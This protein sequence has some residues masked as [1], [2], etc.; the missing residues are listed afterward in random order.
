MVCFDRTLLNN[1]MIIEQI[2]GLGAMTLDSLNVDSKR[3]IAPA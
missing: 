2:S 1:K 3:N